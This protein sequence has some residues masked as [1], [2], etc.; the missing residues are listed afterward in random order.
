MHRKFLNASILIVTASLLI[1]PL[2][3]AAGAG[4]QPVEWESGS[5]YRAPLSFLGQGWQISGD[6]C[7]LNDYVMRVNKNYS[8]DPN[9]FRIYS[10]KSQVQSVFSGKTVIGHN[11]DGTSA[12]LCLGFRNTLSA[13]GPV[14]VASNLFVWVK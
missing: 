4:S 13:G 12:Y 5:N 11:L 7:D 3:Q 10:Y 2:A 8:A 9:R 6:K 1:V 14:N